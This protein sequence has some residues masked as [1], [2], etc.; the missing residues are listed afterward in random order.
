M[1][2]T[3]LEQQIKQGITILKQGGVIAYPTDTIY[4]LGCSAYLPE[5]VERVYRIKQRP[6]NMALPILLASVTRIAEVAVDISPVAWRLAERFLPGALT[7][8]LKKA[9]SVPDIVTAGGKTVAV[10]VPAHP[11]T[12]ALI[13]GLGTPL[14]GTSANISG[15]PNPLTAAD[16]RRQ[17]GNKVDLIIDGGRCPG[18]TESTVVDLTGERPQ[19]LREG[20]IKRGEVEVSGN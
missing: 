15:Q 18:G 17:L 2:K 13:E 20:A 7:L 16:V 10:R 19:I 1:S 14:V 9:D 12:I 5:A 4:G 8:V 11:V 3:T 6:R